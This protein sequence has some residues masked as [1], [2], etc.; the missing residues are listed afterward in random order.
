MRPSTTAKRVSLFILVHLACSVPHRCC[1]ESPIRCGP[2]ASWQA[3]RL[4]R[5]NEQTTTSVRDLP[6][7]PSHRSG[8]TAR[9]SASA[10]AHAARA[11]ISA[12]NKKG[13]G[14]VKAVSVLQPHLVWRSR[15]AD[16][17]LCS[18]NPEFLLPQNVIHIPRS[19]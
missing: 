9:G 2:V 10:A 16:A 18:V 14:F 11:A 17:D 3:E 15:N 19:L 4:L 12:S 5:H 13:K 7:L 1:R 8:M 6:T